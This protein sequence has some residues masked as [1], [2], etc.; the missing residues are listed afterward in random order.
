LLIAGRLRDLSGALLPLPLGC[1]LPA[2]R[3]AAFGRQFRV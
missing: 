1:A 3:F 2:L